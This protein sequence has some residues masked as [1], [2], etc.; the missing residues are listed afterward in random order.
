MYLDV[1]NEGIEY[2]QK[3]Q[4]IATLPSH[5]KLFELIFKAALELEKFDTAYEYYKARKAVLP[6]A[7]SYLA[8]LDLIKFKEKTHQPIISDLEALIRDVIPD[9]IKLDALKKLL[10]LYLEEHQENKALPIIAEMKKL[11]SKQSYVPQYL[12]TLL[13]LGMFDDAKKIA[14]QYKGHY[15][16]DMDSYLTLL[17][18]YMHEKDTHRAMI[19][20]AEYEA[21]LE[22]MPN[23]FQIEAIK[24]LVELYKLLNNRLSLDL[25]QK[26]LKNLLKTEEKKQKLIDKEDKEDEPFAKSDREIITTVVQKSYHSKHLEDIIDL[27]TYAHQIAET[28]SIRDFLRTYFMKCDEKTLV[29][30]YIVFTKQDEMLYHYKKERLY[31]K[32][33]TL[34]TYEQT[35][36]GEVLSDGD[37]RFGRPDSFKYDIDI[38]TSKSFDEGVR[39]IYAYPL[40]D[41]GVFMVYLDQ[42]IN[43]PAVY[44]D[45][46]K[47]ISGII[48]SYFMDE[49]KRGKLRIDNEFYEKILSSNLLPIRILSEY[50]TSYNIFAQKL[51]NVESHEPLE[52]YYHHMDALSIKNY[53]M[54]IQR[55]MQKGNLQ[56]EIVY[57]LGTRQIREKVISMRHGDD[58][59]LISVFEDL[60]RFYEEKNKLMM[61]ATIDFETSLQNLNALQQKLPEYLKDKGSFMLINFNDSIKAIYGYDATLQFFKEFGQL[62]KKFFEDGEVYRFNTYQL[63]VYVPQNDIRSVTKLIKDYLKMIDSY[64]SKVIS[65]EKFQP[66]LAIIRYPVVTEEKNPAKL[67]R[68]LEISLD[69]L[70]HQQSVD[71]YIFFEHRIYEEEVYE[72]QIID[73]LNEAMEHHQ[74]SLSFNQ[75]IDLSRSVVWQYE[76]ELTLEN[77]N[78]DSKYLL[79]IAKKRNRLIDLDK[80]HI[81]MVCEFLH[82]LEQETG[83]LIKITIPIAKETFID[84]TFNPYIFGQF[85]AFEI[86]SE[87][88][89]FKVRMN[90]LKAGQYVPQIDE[91]VNS[92]VGLD[93]TSVEVALS[94]PFNAVHLDFKKQDPKWQ[95]YI[96]LLKQLLENHGMALV[97]REVKT[98]EQKDLLET[99]G[100]KFIE[101]SLYKRITAETLLYKIKGSE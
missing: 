44:F 88:I 56:D 57:A 49:Q 47:G 20:D 5:E 85:Q 40:Y 53:Q 48:Y 8:S 33:L 35:L 92:G 50:Q 2:H 43:D 14:L 51:L 75:I 18:V 19:L 17:K 59:K 87:F 67:F 89:R 70:T 38:L 63:F 39:Y 60:S 31:D 42:D 83:K 46:F 12:K 9:D 72:Q 82:I 7:K 45:L 21:K 81:K 13:S 90:D 22:T 73:Y 68:F 6:V 28:K 11:D 16:Y 55:L 99:L 26:K 86:P 4:D 37:E 96:R 54:M 65:Y 64:E 24:L 93:T 100:I 76:S 41:L 29:K 94:Y 78:I 91:L 52:L 84:P 1:Y 32:Q 27:L 98:K 10:T 3:N 80:Y 62:T 66:K 101:G 79:V 95:D 69:H 74:L 15:L 30:S 71:P 61:E 23:D 25:Y 36:I 77:V 58:I 34:T 97:I